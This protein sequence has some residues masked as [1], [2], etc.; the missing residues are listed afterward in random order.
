M[1]LLSPDGKLPWDESL[2]EGTIEQK[3]TAR[4]EKKSLDFLLKNTKNEFLQ[5]FLTLC[6][7]LEFSEV[8]D[9]YAIHN[10]VLQMR[11]QYHLAHS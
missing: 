3:K 7:G 9:Y 5:K 1:Y 6:Y 2:L 4:T 8:P 10:C 11:N